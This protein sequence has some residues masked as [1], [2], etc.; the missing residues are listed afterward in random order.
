MLLSPISLNSPLQRTFP[1]IQYFYEALNE[2]KGDGFS[3]VHLVDVLTQVDDT[4]EFK[5]ED[6]DLDDDLPEGKENDI[7]ED[8]YM[9]R[10]EPV[11][12]G[13]DVDDGD[14]PDEDDEDEDLDKLSG[15]NAAEAKL[16]LPD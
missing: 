1:K 5:N 8:I 3:N 16:P 10:E 14:K 4:L 7:A 9:E 2:I 13:D 6:G 15:E 12:D 11:E